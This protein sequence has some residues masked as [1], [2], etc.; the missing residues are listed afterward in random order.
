VNE[1][2]LLERRVADKESSRNPWWPPSWVTLTVAAA[3]GL[4]AIALA[5]A[6]YEIADERGENQQECVQTVNFRRE[7]RAMWLE[8]FEAFPEAAEE[9]GLRDDL[10]NLLPPLTCDGSTPIPIPEG[11][12]P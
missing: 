4:L 5:T 6:W 8:L 1:P 12:T 11:A 9:T 10:E 3:L 7:N 2:E